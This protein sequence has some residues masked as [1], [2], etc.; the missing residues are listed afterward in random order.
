MANGDEYFGCVNGADIFCD[1]RR[2]I[3]CL[4]RTPCGNHG[5]DYNAALRLSCERK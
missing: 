5:S 2:G 3:R 4:A 1:C